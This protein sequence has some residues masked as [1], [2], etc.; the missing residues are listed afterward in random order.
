MTLTA[1]QLATIT[2]IGA[3]I[4]PLAVSFLKQEHW[5]TWIKQAIAFTISFAVA[6]VGIAATTTN[7]STINIAAIVG[8]AYTGSQVVYQAYFR[9]SAFETTLTNTFSKKPP[10]PPATPV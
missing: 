4:I 7:W 9:N 10:T 3:A 1:A 5:A 8:L 6:A 2:A